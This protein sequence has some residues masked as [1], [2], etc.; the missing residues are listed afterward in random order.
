MSL[1]EFELRDFRWIVK[2]LKFLGIRKNL[3]GKCLTI[4]HAYGCFFLIFGRQANVIYGQSIFKKIFSSFLIIIQFKK[5][6]APYQTHN[7]LNSNIYFHLLSTILWCFLCLNFTILTSFPLY[8]NSVCTRNNIINSIIYHS[9][10][11]DCR[12]SFFFCKIGVSSYKLVVY[13]SMTFNKV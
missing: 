8:N 10:I 6:N 11:S 3:L 4:F 13:T 5:N 9:I 12:K 1:I 2:A 7:I